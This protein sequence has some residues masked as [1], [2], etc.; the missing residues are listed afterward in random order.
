MPHATAATPRHTEV[1]AGSFHTP[2]TVLDALT[3]YGRNGAVAVEEAMALGREFFLRPSN[4]TRINPISHGGKTDRQLRRPGRLPG[5]LSASIR[6][7]STRH[8]SPRSGGGGAP[9]D[10][11]TSLAIAPVVGAPGRVLVERSRSAF[12]VVVGSR[13]RDPVEGLLL[14]SVSRHVLQHAL[15]T[16]AVVP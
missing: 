8:G 7:P 6:C 3:T 5:A 15:C 11:R 12:R 2:I 4:S 16:V 13:G 10:L 1:N 9:L 14:G